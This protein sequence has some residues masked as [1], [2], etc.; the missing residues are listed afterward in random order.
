MYKPQLTHGLSGARRTKAKK[1]VREIRVRRAASGGFISEIH[2]EPDEDG[3]PQKPEEHIVPS[4]AAL[5][6][7]VAQQLGPDP[8]GQDEQ[9]SPLAGLR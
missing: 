4:P 3:L 2:H 7:H 1:H 8:N 6:D 9:D 5:R